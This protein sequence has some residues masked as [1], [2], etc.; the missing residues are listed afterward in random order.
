MAENDAHQHRIRLFLSYGRRDAADLANRLRA[1]LENLGY[2]VWQDTRKIRAGKEWE[3]EIQ[4]G[5]RSTQVVIALLSPHAVRRSTNPDNPDNVDSVCLDELTFARFATPPTPI[6][7]VMAIACEPPFTVFRLDYIEMTRWSQSEDEYRRGFE[8]LTQGIEAAVKG[9]PLPFRRWYHCLPVLDFAPQLHDKRQGFVGRQ[10]LLDDIDAWRVAH[11]ERALLITGDPGI[12][13]SAFVA[14]MIH[15]DPGGRVLAYHIC[16]ADDPET[17]RPSTFIMSLTGMMAGRLPAFADLLEATRFQELF[18]PR[19]VSERPSHVFDQGLISALHQL[20]APPD[21]S[22]YLLIDALDEAL[23]LGVGQLNIVSLLSTRLERFPAWLRIVATTRRDPDVLNRLS[24]LRA[25]SID[26]HRQDNLDDIDRFIES[27]LQSPNLAERLVAS[28]VSLATVQQKLRASAEGNFLYVS[29]ALQD[30]ERDNYSFDRLDEL[31]GGLKGTYASFFER[32]F[33]SEASY[34]AARV[35]LEV[36]LAAQQPLTRAQ[37]AKAAA[38]DSV[39]ALNQVLVKLSTFLDASAGGV[40]IYHKSLSDW[41]IGTTITAPHRFIVSAASGH[42]RLAASCS[43]ALTR[44]WETDGTAPKDTPAGEDGNDRWAPD[45]TTTYALDHFPSH[46]AASGHRDRLFQLLTSFRYIDARVR[47]GQ[48]FALARNLRE[49]MALFPPESPDYAAL[50][51]IEQSLRRDS[52]FINDYRESYPQGLFQ[53]AYNL[54]HWSRTP[55]SGTGVSPTEKAVDPIMRAWESDFRQSSLP[56]LRSLRPPDHPLG[57]DQCIVYTRHQAEVRSLAVSGNGQLLVSGSDDG[58]V[59]VHHIPTGEV[60]AEWSMPGYKVAGTLFFG[61]DR[62]LALCGRDGELV[63]SCWELN[64]WERKWSHVLAGTDG[65]SSCCVPSHDA[66]E[67]VIG[68]GLGIFRFPFPRDGDDDE[69]DVTSLELVAGDFHPRTAVWSRDAAVAAFG[70]S[71]HVRVF[72]APARSFRKTVTVPDGSGSGTVPLAISNDGRTL[73]IATWTGWPGRESIHFY[74]TKSGVKSRAVRHSAD[75][76]PNS[77]DF[78]PCSTKIASGTND[79]RIRV[80]DVKSL[81]LSSEYEGHESYVVATRWSPN[82]DAVFS[83]GTDGSVLGW[84]VTKRIRKHRRV[85]HDGKIYS[86]AVSDDQ[87]LVASGCEAG[88]LYVWDWESGQ[89]VFSGE[90]FHSVTGIVFSPDGSLV[91][92]L[93]SEDGNLQVWNVKRGRELWH[94]RG[95]PYTGLRGEKRKIHDVVNSVVFNPTSETLGCVEGGYKERKAVVF[96]R[97][98]SGEEVRRV[99]DPEENPTCVAFSPTNGGF[100]IGCES[101]SIQLWTARGKK[102]TATLTGPLDDVDVLAFHPSQPIIIGAGAGGG[103]VAWIREGRNW[104]RLWYRNA[105]DHVGKRLVFSPGGT[106]VAIICDGYESIIISYDIFNGGKNE[107]TQ[108]VC[109]PWHRFPDFDGKAVSEV[110]FDTTIIRSAQTGAVIGRLPFRLKSLVLNR[111]GT[112]LAGVLGRELHLYSIEVLS[113]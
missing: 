61:S 62:L 73:A 102:P 63:I 108:G 42:A 82:G 109:S 64:T 72:D 21:G 91:A 107:E 44:V 92:T 2:E 45:E 99:I 69:A 50:F 38:I 19:S 80:W 33:P 49:A 74:D 68:N 81:T 27:R 25:A 58:V 30:I 70:T 106:M 24:G 5:L 84:D 53:S 93:G 47:G 66:Q 4:D 11:Q 54:L 104:E 88:Q 89:T 9:Q 23:T 17:L 110:T 43:E 48:L 105:P 28:R 39:Y 10:W 13:K 41:L 14:E 83:G 26:A 51:L 15:R 95:E 98:N 78:A 55:T 40:R 46:L 34:A 3:Q 100:A 6:V 37:I 85:G 101:G 94:R 112:R 16:R 7:P 103:I 8:R 22:R 111:E 97:S 36:L 32:A 52:K 12:G 18:D 56:W 79:G 60:M 113:A 96:R 35:V 59:R 20:H 87:K 67:L 76:W 71:T 57:L 65:A 31:P 75:N 29:Q 1:D 90:C 86:L 77:I